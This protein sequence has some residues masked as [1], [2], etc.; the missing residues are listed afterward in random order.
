[1]KPIYLDHN[2]SAPLRPEALHALAE[3]SAQLFGNPSSAHAFGADARAA[4]SRA[5]KQV[6]SLAGVAPDA[7]VFTSGATE[8][9][10]TVL[11]QV[12]SGAAVV[13]S[14]TEHPSVLEEVAALRARGVRVRV[15]GVARVGGLDPARFASALT[16][17]CALASVQW[18]NSETGV[19]Q[20][21]AEL[22]R[23]AAARGVPFHCDAAQALGKLPLE[24]RALPIDY[25]SLSAHKLGG[26]KGVGALCVR[27]GAALAP[28]FRGGG[29]ERG[30]RAG[31]ENVPAIAAFGAACAAGL[32]ELALSAERLA[33]LRDSLWSGIAR[34]IPDAARTGSAE[35]VLPHVLDVSFA[36]ASGEAL[37]EALDLEGI[38]VS[39]GAACHS[40]STEPSPVLRAMGVSDELARSALRFSLGPSNDRAEI[41]RVLERLREIVARVRRARAA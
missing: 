10:N 26:P 41:E 38:A 22:A 35:H 27:P 25:A 11:R 14:A 15:L 39:T 16:T 24:L 30:R 2:A 37:V 31:T 17:E 3:A 34:A 6:A 7:L 40:G 21:I 12:P 9:N 28:F 18:A 23:A 32:R 33:A 13:T 29:Q 1:M 19:I 5:R 36:G 4:L 8:S 20:P